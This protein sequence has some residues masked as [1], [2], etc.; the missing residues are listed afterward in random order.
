MF[1][2][3]LSPQSPAD[4]GGNLSSEAP[5]GPT[6]KE[7]HRSAKQPQARSPSPT[8]AR[9]QPRPVTNLEELLKNASVNDVETCDKSALAAVDVAQQLIK[10]KD[11][12]DRQDAEQLAN[13][14]LLRA[15]EVFNEL[16][17]GAKGFRYEDGYQVSYNTRGE[18]RVSTERSEHYE[19]DT[20]HVIVTQY[21]TGLSFMYWTNKTFG[22]EALSLEECLFRFGMA[23]WKRPNGM[24]GKVIYLDETQ[25]L[26]NCFTLMLCHNNGRNVASRQQEKD[27]EVFRVWRSAVPDE[28]KDVIATGELINVR[29]GKKAPRWFE[30]ELDSQ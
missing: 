2:Q 4:S 25:S 1:E 30:M 28:L 21:P 19:K 17:D 15:G 13:L 18:Y 22:D 3:M 26:S 5:R 20:V 24:Q 16:A 6:A 10:E 8:K 14:P 7:L 29:N 9:R 11:E 12:V 27:P 23:G